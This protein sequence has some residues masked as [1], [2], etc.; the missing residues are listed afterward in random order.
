MPNAPSPILGL[1]I[2]TVGGDVNQWGYELN[3]N[4][5]PTIDA[6]GATPVNVI[7]ASSTLVPAISP[8]TIGLC[9]GGAAGITVMLSC[10]SIKPSIFILSK[11]D[12]AVGTITIVPLTG[13]I[14]PGGLTSYIL[15]NQ[16]QF[17]W[18]AFDGAN[19][20]VIAAN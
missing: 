18:L 16:G 12:A 13:L 17:V 15:S 10:P 7:A 4:L 20:N 19:Y 1:I 5:Y 11:T 3:T 14:N 9:T 6:L 2:P 8:F